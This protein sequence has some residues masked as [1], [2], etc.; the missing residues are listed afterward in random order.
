MRVRS[1]TLPVALDGMVNVNT[2]YIWLA[3]AD[4]KLW[5]PTEQGAHGQQT[6]LSQPVQC[7]QAPQKLH[8]KCIL[9][10]QEV[11]IHGNIV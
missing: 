7:K 2:Q 1:W 4:N 6:H 9:D 10:C 8:F 3:P 5:D 11:A